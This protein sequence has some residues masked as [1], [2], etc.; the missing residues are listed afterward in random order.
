[1]EI[2]FSP[3]TIDNI[4]TY[5]TSKKETLAIAESVTAGFLQAAFST[6]QDASLFFEGG[7]TAYNINQKIKHLH[8]NKEKAVACN[9]VSEQ[10][11][12]E[13]ALGIIKMFGSQWS[14]AITGYSSPVKE[15]DF[16]L[17][18]WFAIAHQQKV[19]LSKKI[20]LRNQDAVQAQLEY[21]SIVLTEF[22]EFLKR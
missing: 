19:L 17:Y 6:A 9:C 8:I 18:A 4:R 15:S 1:M 10:T 22:E 16:Q 21:T 3:L 5:I 11:A 13:M 12:R 14:V 20:E 2:N 7:I